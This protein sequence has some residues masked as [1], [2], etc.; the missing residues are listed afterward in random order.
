MT[1]NLSSSWITNAFTTADSRVP[2]TGTDPDFLES[3][4]Q[5]EISETSPHLEQGPGPGPQIILPESLTR[6]KNQRAESPLR[7]QGL[8]DSTPVLLSE[9]EDASEQ[10]RSGELE[11]GPLLERPSSRNGASAKAALARAREILAKRRV[12]SEVIPG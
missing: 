12:S 10:Y 11:D 7:Q 2:S 3:S 6:E 8:H 1:P 5:P 4:W 9:E